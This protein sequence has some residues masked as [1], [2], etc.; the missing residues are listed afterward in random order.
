MACLRLRTD[1]R[2]NWRCPLATKSPAAGPPSHPPYHSVWHT[3]CSRSFQPQQWSRWGCR[4]S[5]HL[6]HHATYNTLHVCP[7]V[8]RLAACRR[9][10]TNKGAKAS[11][12][13]QTERYALQNSNAETRTFTHRA[14]PRALEVAGLLA[15]AFRCR[16][17]SPRAPRP[18]R[19]PRRAWLRDMQL[20]GSGGE[21][22]REILTVGWKGAAP[23][24]YPGHLVAPPR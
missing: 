19:R 17:V 10:C 16:T 13:P 2:T 6:P 20:L 18:Q 21:E 15:S 12:H 5:S 4:R 23:Y 24:G 8:P 7:G 3:W 11:T 1:T 14:R 9:V 22:K